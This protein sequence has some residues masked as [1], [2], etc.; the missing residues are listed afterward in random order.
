[1]RATR[2]R[3]QH[4]VAAF[5]SREWRETVPR[6]R[7]RSRSGVSVSLT[8]PALANVSAVA[9]GG[10]GNGA[11]GGPVG[12]GVEVARARRMLHVVLVSPLVSG[13]C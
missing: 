7:S 4:R 5:C 13:S 1:V 11:A 12:S 3:R 8:S 9:V 2:L 6:S 10:D